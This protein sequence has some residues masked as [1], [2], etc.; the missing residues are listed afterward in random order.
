VEHLAALAT[1]ILSHRQ[2]IDLAANTFRAE[3]ASPVK[4]LGCLCDQVDRVIE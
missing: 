4:L 3:P 2:N 1:P